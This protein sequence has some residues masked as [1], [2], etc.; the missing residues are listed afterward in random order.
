MDGFRCTPLS[1]LLTGFAWLLLAALAGVAS[2]IGLVQGTPLP[3]WLRQIHTHGALVGGLLQMAIGGLLAVLARVSN[4]KKPAS[5]TLLFVLLNGGTLALLLCM[6]LRNNLLIGLAGLFLSAVV[7][8]ITRE[9]SV[10]LRVSLAGPATPAWVLQGSLGALLIGWAIGLAMAFGLVPDYYAHA[11]L[12]HL[13][14]ILIGF[15]TL[16]G[17]ALIHRLLPLLLS[18]D[19]SSVAL[20]RLATVIFV[21]G[22]AALIGGFVSSSLKFELALGLLLIAGVGLMV[23]NLLRTWLQAGSVGSAAGDHVLIAGVFLLLTT[24]TGLLMG[25]NYL[26]DPPTL[27]IGSLHLSAYTHMALVGFMVNVVFG[28]LSYGVPILVAEDRIASPKK[29]APYLE[30]LTGI[31]NRWRAAQLIAVSLGTMGLAVVAAMTWSV[32]LGSTAVRIATWVTAGLLVSGFAL[33]AAKLVWAIGTEP[34]D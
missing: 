6:T 13:H 30:Q 32:P 10:H 34:T 1:F 22:A 2:L 3:T 24:V 18:R 21:I 11:R 33:I 16:V 7:L 4:G 12:L 27:P 23:F 29:R 20:G 31:M 25:A 15:F 26:S 19:L 5:R 8:S 28:A 14:L 9:A 17:I